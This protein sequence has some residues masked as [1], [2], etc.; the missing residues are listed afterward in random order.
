MDRNTTWS[1]LKYALGPGLLMAAAAVGVS[2]LVQSTRAG[3]DYGFMLIWAIVLA[4]FFKYPFLEFGPRYAIATNETMLEGIKR[5]GS[6]AKWVF[7]LFTVLSMFTIQAAVTIVTASLAQKLIGI[8]LP[9]WI[10]SAIVLMVIVSILSVGRYSILDSTIKLIMVVL[11]ISTLAAIAFAAFNH[12]P[13]TQIAAQPEIWNFAG[14]SFL[15][16]LMGWMPIPVDAA[17]WHS[18]WT[19]ERIKQTGH[20]PRLRD[21]LIDFNIGYIGAAILAVAFMS[22]GALVLYGKGVDL[23][24]SGAGFANQFVNIYTETLGNWTYWI[25]IICAF[26]TMFSTTITV[27]D[28]YPRITQRILSLELKSFSESDRSYRILLV[29]ISIV[30]VALLYFLGDNFSLMVDL[31]TSMSFLMAPVLAYI[32]HKLVHSEQVPDKMKPPRWLN[33]LSKAG[34]VFLSGFALLFVLWNFISGQ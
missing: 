11:S 1:T 6:W 25:I 13:N 33:L 15:I 9:P 18:V 10:W 8:T 5:L 22:L 2:H 19:H 21:S 14:V 24:G 23:A 28:A 16:A 34:L 30:S 26:S 12:Q 32:N 20:T 17:V 31:A 4:N 29:L 27:T 3:A 7:I